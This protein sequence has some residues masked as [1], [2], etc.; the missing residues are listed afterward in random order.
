MRP[1]ALAFAALLLVSSAARAEEPV[2]VEGKL[3]TVYLFKVS[4]Y[5]PCAN[6][7]YPLRTASGKG[8]PTNATY[9]S[10]CFVGSCE[11]ALEL[12]EGETAEY[13]EGNG[14]ACVKKE[15]NADKPGL[16]SS[17][18]GT[19]RIPKSALPENFDAAAWPKKTRNGS[20]N[21]HRLAQDAVLLSVIYETKPESDQFAIGD[22]AFEVKF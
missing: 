2:S 4:D 8:K 6:E 15:A 3:R 9:T 21:G 16:Q 19:I 18:G 22:K 1:L 7:T 11:L 5:T 12:N 14:D 13:Y 10:S 20:V 17:Y